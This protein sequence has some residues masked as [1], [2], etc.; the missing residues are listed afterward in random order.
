MQLGR[1]LRIVLKCSPKLALGNIIC[2][3]IQG[4]IPLI[5]L[6][7]IKLI[8]DE[9]TVGLSIADK[10]SSFNHVL[11]LVIIAGGVAVISI[12]CN[13]SARLL[14][15]SHSL[16]VT[17]HIQRILHSK[18][19]EIDLNYYENPQYYNTLHRAQQ[20]APYRP[21]HI[22]NGLI[23]VAQSSVSAAAM[24]FLM[25]RFHWI[26]TVAVFVAVLPEIYVKL[27]FSGKLYNWQRRV[28]QDERK[29]RYY[30]WIL[31]TYA[32][33]K[34]IRLF[35]LG[36]LFLKRYADLRGKLRSERL[37]ISRDRSLAE[38]FT[39]TVGVLVVFGAYGFI[40]YR[41]IHG[42]ITIGD[43]VMYFQAFRQAVSYL[44]NILNGVAG[45]Y[46]DNLFLNNLFEFLDLKPIVVD[47]I[48]PVSVPSPIKDGVVF[49]SVSF[50]YPSI[51]RSA[52]DDVSIRFNPGEVTALVG[53]NGSGKTTLIKLLCRL[54]DPS[55]GSVTI[56]GVDL[57]EF[58][59]VELRGQISVLFQ[60][61]VRYQMMVNEN[62]WFSDT[63]EPLDQD[64]IKNAAQR[65]EIEEV[66]N[67]L[68]NGFE[69]V[70]GKWFDD[71]VE[72]SEGEWQKIAF[73]RTLNKDAQIIILDE[74]TSAM[75]AETEHEIFR[76]L[77]PLVRDKII[78]LI[79]H[80]F[81]TVR[82]ADRIYILDGGRI[83]EQGSHGELL[84]QNG[85][86]AR[87]FRESSEFYL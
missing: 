21:N 27:K 19:I 60:D 46:E 51:A 30:G 54:Y 50:Q 2:L 15:E 10:S 62:I 3:L 83:S 52:L 47:P 58:N 34:E 23:Q 25:F 71:S 38:L 85:Y 42:V 43:L 84:R 33:A 65:A 70:L 78:I 39:Q 57:R 79:S 37:K 72:L 20:E 31:S 77:K 80:R 81:S 9:V 64:R 49:N 73:A 16:I 35:N 4:V 55:T 44:R 13:L 48:K 12:I 56:D 53:K 67:R 24:L 82:A 69:T 14:G 6:Y 74:P 17:D 28:T 45:L 26:V 7:L 59:T 8:I 5:S 68:P 63:T 40:V 22:F 1:A 75:D 61:Y 41:A 87:L 11:M 86:Y 32:Y 29:S 18:S 76:R 66:I 36:S